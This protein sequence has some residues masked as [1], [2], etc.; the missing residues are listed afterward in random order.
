MTGKPWEAMYRAVTGRLLVIADSDDDDQTLLADF[1]R[2]AHAHVGLLD[3]DE[4]FDS[5]AWVAWGIA[6]GFSSEGFCRTHDHAA[7]T[8]T[9]IQQF[10]KGEDPCVPAVRVYVG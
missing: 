6:A 1:K 8:D 3:D 10:D 2:V 5:R 7:L 4:P 9:E